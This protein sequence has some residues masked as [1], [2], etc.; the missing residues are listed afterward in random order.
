MLIH[1]Q[2]SNNR[3]ELHKRMPF[4]SIAR[5]AGDFQREYGTDPALAHLRK[6]PLES[7]ADRRPPARASLILIDH[8][9]VPPA[10]FLGVLLQRVLTATALLMVAHLIWRGLPDVDIGHAREMFR[11]DL[12]VH[13]RA[14]AAHGALVNVDAKSPRTAMR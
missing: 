13:D 2:C 9:H 4:A 11:R 8:R 6:Q 14:P 7:R 3:A 1:Q 12:V 10:E 5:E